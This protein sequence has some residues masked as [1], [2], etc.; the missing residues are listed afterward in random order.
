MRKITVMLLKTDEKETFEAVKKTLDFLEFRRNGTVLVKPNICMPYYAPGAITSPQLLREIVGLLR[1]TAEDVIVAESDGYNYSCTAAFKRTGIEAAVKNAGGRILNLSRDRI[2]RVNIKDPQI[3]NLLLPK[4]LLEVDALVNV[5]VMKTHEFTLYSGAVKNLF[6][7]IP[8]S[9]RIFLHPYLNETLYHLLMLL[10]PTA[11]IMDALTAMEGRGP[12]RGMPVKLNLIMASNSPLALDVT[13]TKIM[14]L[15]WREVGHLAYIAKKTR[16]KEE[17]IRIL[18]CSIE[19][20]ARNF[21]LPKAD[22]PTKLQHK[23]FQHE[24]LTKILFYNTGFIKLCQ[25]LLN[26]YRRFP[27]AA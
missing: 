22:I 25:K 10:K 4:T 8:D 27:I 14:R 16:F 23:I 19:E 17:N 2:V 20:F 24:L 5:P 3:R 26:Q 12:T 9:R 7:L 21:A 18:G 13:A 15:H 6:G 1:E 11:N